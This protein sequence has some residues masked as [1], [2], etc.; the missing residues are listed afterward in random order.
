MMK[1]ALSHYMHVKDFLGDKFPDK[2]S[3]YNGKRHEFKMW[4]AIYNILSPSGFYFNTA[5][6]DA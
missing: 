3:I 1:K 6:L 2:G 4:S 5:R